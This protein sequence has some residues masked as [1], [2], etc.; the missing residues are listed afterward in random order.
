MS[1]T[2]VLR[3]ITR[4]SLR[5]SQENWFTQ[6]SRYLDRKDLDYSPDDKAA[7]ESGIVGPLSVSGW[8]QDA[9]DWDSYATHLMVPQHLMLAY[10]LTPSNFGVG[11]LVLH[12]KQSGLSPIFS[13]RRVGFLGS[14]T[15][16]GGA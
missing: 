8:Y 11:E 4:R 1:L 14:A 16:Y 5:D 3:P 7:V 15:G 9:G 10:Q 6:K 2:R 13:S 12:D